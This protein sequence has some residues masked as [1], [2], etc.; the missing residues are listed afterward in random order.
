MTLPYKAISQKQIKKNN[1]T[2]I[3][4]AIFHK[5]KYNKKETI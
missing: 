1:R 3:L 2:L 5:S 4:S